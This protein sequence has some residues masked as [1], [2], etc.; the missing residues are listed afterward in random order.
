M[1]DMWLR[2][3]VMDRVV[4]FVNDL[5]MHPQQGLLVL[6]GIVVVVIWLTRKR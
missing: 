3:A 2:G 5:V 6:G 4:G 1:Y